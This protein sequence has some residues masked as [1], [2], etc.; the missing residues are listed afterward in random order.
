M[1]EI[2][3]EA[4]TPVSR[5]KKTARKCPFP[6]VIC[7]GC[8]A[9]SRPASHHLLPLLFPNNRRVGYPSAGETISTQHEKEN[10]KVAT[11]TPSNLISS[12]KL[13]KVM[14]AVAATSSSPVG[15]I[16]ARTIPGLSTVVALPAEAD[17][18]FVCHV[19]CFAMSSVLWGGG[20]MGSIYVENLPHLKDMNSSCLLLK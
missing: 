4:E 8:D 12:A 7:P 5:K 16:S 9:A 18:G 19:V 17:F 3:T 11:P 10:K 1:V 6:P 13:T 14:T 20:Q 2:E 15:A